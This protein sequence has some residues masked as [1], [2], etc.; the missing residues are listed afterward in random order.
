MDFPSNP[1]DGQISGN[2]IY[3]SSSGVWKSRPLVGT[4]T[5]HSPVVPLNANPGDVWFNTTDGT[6]FTYFDD[7]TSKQWVEILIS[8]SRSVD[9]ASILVLGGI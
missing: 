3:S 4:I 2:Y 9:Y 7:G 8:S 6:A 5:I 1:I